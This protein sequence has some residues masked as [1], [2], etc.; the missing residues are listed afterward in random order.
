MDVPFSTVDKE[1]ELTD[2]R[3][4]AQW[5]YWIMVPRCL[6]EKGKFLR[7]VMKTWGEF[8]CVKYTKHTLPF[9]ISLF[10]FSFFFTSFFL[11][12]SF[13]SLFSIYTFILYK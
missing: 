1:R 5:L 11:L 10:L 4:R 9:L 13:S 8:W 6:S 2:P 3:N 7:L 12:F